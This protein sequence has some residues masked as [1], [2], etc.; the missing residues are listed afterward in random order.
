MRHPGGAT[1]AYGEFF[2]LYESGLWRVWLRG[3][4]DES[5][6]LLGSRKSNQWGPLYQLPRSSAMRS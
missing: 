5:P 3:R 4:G 1:D 6:P 2:S